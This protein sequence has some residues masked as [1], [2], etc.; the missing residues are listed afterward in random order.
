[1]KKIIFLLLLIPWRGYSQE[2]ASSDQLLDMLNGKREEIGLP[3]VLPDPILMETA[4]SYAFECLTRGTISHRD[5][6][7]DTAIERLKAAGSSAVTV[8]EILG[9]GPSVGVVLNAWMESPSHLKVLSGPQWTHCGIGTAQVDGKVAA[10]ALF[11]TKP[12]SFIRVNEET[13]GLTITAGY[14]GCPPG[15]PFVFTG[16]LYIGPVQKNR[17]DGVVVFF[18]DAKRHVYNLIFGVKTDALRTYTDRVL[19]VKK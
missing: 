9:S 7:G 6:N 16:D 11:R 10:V 19:V 13:S 17:E 3:A 18:V 12:F 14:S 4:Y 15:E 5:R 1:M 2:T 8:G